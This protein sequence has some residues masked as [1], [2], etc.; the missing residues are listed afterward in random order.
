MV[1]DNL[2]SCPLPKA[3]STDSSLQD[4][5]QTEFTQKTSPSQAATL[6]DLEEKAKEHSFANAIAAKELEDSHNEYLDS[7]PFNKRK[8]Y[9]ARRWRG[10][11]YGSRLI[12]HVGYLLQCYHF[13]FGLEGKPI[14]PSKETLAKQVGICVRT[15][16]KALAAL[17]AM[18]VI[19][20]FSGKKFWE[21]NTYI[22]SQAYSMKP[23]RRPKDF[24]IPKFLW[25]KLQYL[26]KKKQLKSLWPTIYE[27][28]LKDIADHLLRREKFLRT[29][30]EE[31]YRKSLKTALDPPKKRKKPPNCQLLKQFNLTFKDQWILGRYSEALL[32]AAIEDLYA[33]RLWGKET[34]N[35]P[36]FLISR[37]KAHKQGQEARQLKAEPSM[38]KEWLTSYFKAHKQ[39]FV[40]ISRES[41][42]DLATSEP[43]PFIQMLWHKE[44]L[45]Q[46]VLKV[47]QKIHGAW[48]DKVFRFDRPDVANAI[49]NYLENSIRD[50]PNA[51]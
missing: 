29:S 14:N 17:K 13:A 18:D 48:V 22:I 30:L 1:T 10:H 5:L 19:D 40:F 50:I 21:T 37:C 51:S 7:L 24:K 33:Y 49:E 43:R 42:I 34:R 6:R 38:I 28:I 16:D 20:W 44:D 4:S 8:R 41:Q 36:A 11:S 47:Y 9:K 15:L 46:S 26:L 32:R 23:M 45:R 3:N 27:H 39:R 25:L 12:V 35:L 2:V 31:K